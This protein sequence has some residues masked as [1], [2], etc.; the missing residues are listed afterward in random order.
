[1]KELQ[2]LLTKIETKL[3]KVEEN[4]EKISGE[5]EQ[6]ERENM[7]LRKLIEDTMTKFDIKKDNDLI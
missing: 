6:Y 2:E 3:D 7:E 4:L 1:M 5:L